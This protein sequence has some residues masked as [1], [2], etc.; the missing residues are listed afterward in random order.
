MTPESQTG[1][2]KVKHPNYMDNFYYTTSNT[3]A[4][5]NTKYDD[6]LFHVACAAMQS[7]APNFH[8]FEIVNSNEENCAKAAVRYARAL[9]K[10]LENEE[11]R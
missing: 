3:T 5:E 9:L 1:F 10:E 6:K 2:E 8:K 4:K 7:L 11:G